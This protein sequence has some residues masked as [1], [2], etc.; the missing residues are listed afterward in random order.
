[1]HRTQNLTAPAADTD[2]F[3]VITPADILRGA[4][5]YLETHG[6]TQHVYYA[7]EPGYNDGRPCQP[8]PPA[9]A[10]GALGMATYGYRSF[11]PSDNLGNPAFPLYRDAADFLG[12]YLERTEHTL[13]LKLASDD[14]AVADLFTWNDTDGQTAEHVIAT[15]RAAADDWTYTHASEDDLE[16]YAEACYAN[17]TQPTR[18]GFLAWVGAR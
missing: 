10:D 13:T 2:D 12:D 3:T 1:M 17:E 9:C 8:F 6:W 14:W 5:T 7:P 15:L 18:D 11:I 16:T 4:A